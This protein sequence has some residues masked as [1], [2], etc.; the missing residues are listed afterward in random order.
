MGHGQCGLDEEGEGADG[1]GED[2]AL[3]DVQVDD[4]DGAEEEGEPGK[5]AD[6]RV[7]FVPVPEMSQI[8]SL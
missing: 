5:P 6:I 7:K 2:E 3:E 4:G 1:F 8:P